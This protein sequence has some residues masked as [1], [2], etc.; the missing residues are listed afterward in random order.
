MFIQIL[1]I[2]PLED[3]IDGD[4]HG[5]ESVHRISGRRRGHAGAGY[6]GAPRPYPAFAVRVR[7]APGQGSREAL[8]D[9]EGGCPVSRSEEGYV[10]VHLGFLLASFLFVLVLGLLIILL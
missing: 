4:P 5:Q 7:Q 2:T 3:L 6:R 9:L 1:L 8:L 10:Q